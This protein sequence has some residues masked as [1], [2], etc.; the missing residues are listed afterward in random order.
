MK[1]VD[2]EPEFGFF[3][4]SQ[5]I[6]THARQCMT[7]AF[8]DSLRE[9]NTKR[10]LHRPLPLSIIPTRVS[11]RVSNKSQQ[12]KKICNESNLMRSWILTEIE[13]TLQPVESIESILAKNRHARAACAQKCLSRSDE[14][15]EKLIFEH[16]QIVMINC[17][18]YWSWCAL[19]WSTCFC[20]S[21][22]SMHARLGAQMASTFTR[23]WNRIWLN[24]T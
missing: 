17:H 20:L 21:K 14:N 11:F 13:L 6:K 19:G 1:Y 10:A 9:K 22:V 16:L 3:F 23:K 8:N 12:K 7:A 15:R 4:S 24:Y 2:V 18:L 5:A